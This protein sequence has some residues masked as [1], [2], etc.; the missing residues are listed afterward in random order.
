LWTISGFADEVDDDFAVQLDFLNSR[1]IRFI[2]LRSAW[3]T[4]VCDLSAPQV[5]RI[6]Q[7]L[8][9]AGIAVSALGTDL[10]K[11]RL[12]DDFAV[13]LDRTRWAT[14][15]AW[16]L[17]TSELRGFSFFMDERDDPQ[18]CRNEVVD[19]LGQMVSIVDSAQIR[20]LHE[21]EADVWG[22]T[23]QR[24]ADLA[25][26]F[27]RSAFGLILDPA[28][29]VQGGVR[30]YSQAYPFV[31]ESTCYVHVK[32]ARLADQT[33]CTAGEGDGQWPE[34][35][36]ALRND[37]YDGF[38]SIEPHLA[39]QEAFGGFSGSDAWAHAHESLIWLLDA[40]GITYS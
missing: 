25:S 31:R 1:G 5:R 4:R 10:G 22:A 15:I 18:A 30:P 35:L 27:P 9:D 13:H 24:C 21:N 17:E 38:L 2:E 29:Y 32:D 36:A 33:I 26:C 16:Y 11:I 20:Y 39:R 19:R 34:L 28:N 23:P 40:A 12:D 37:G 14:D 6:K 3:G 8:D 7:M